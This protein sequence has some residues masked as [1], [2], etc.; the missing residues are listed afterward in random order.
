MKRILLLAILT[1][2]PLAA[3]QPAPGPA[4][5]VPH[6][7]EINTTLMET[8]FLIAGPSAR[9][10]EENKIR[11]GTCFVMLRRLKAD[12]D[13]GQYTLVTARH[14]F[15]D[16]KGEQA[17]VSLRKLNA[18]GEA[19]QFQ[20]HLKIRE[21]GKNLYTPHPTADVSAIDVVLPNDSIIVQLKTEITNVD[22][23]ATDEFLKNIQIHPGDEIECLGYPMQLA[24]ND[25]GYP[26]LGS[27]K[28]ASYP[29]IPLKKVNKIL[30]RF[31]AQPGYSGGPVY[32]SF[33]GRPF[34]GRIPFG[35][36]MT[37]QKLFGLVVQKADPVGDADPF[38]AVIVPSIYIKET[39]DILS[40]FESTI[41]EDQ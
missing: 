41:K 38:I 18:A 3:Q 33:T 1:C 14:V 29:I 11:Y 21:A 25:A 13:G 10:G 12:S 19:E 9:P 39:I 5:N 34:K 32:L 6:S 37:Y 16:I 8:T 4:P 7:P 26:I 36:L 27:G 31:Q 17:D 40:G 30:Y 22:W 24:S 28:I 2:V 35:T 20:F 23:L 15:E